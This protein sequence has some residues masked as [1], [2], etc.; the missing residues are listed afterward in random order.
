MT[1]DNFCFY[2][3]NR[4]IQTSQTGG[5][6]YS[7][8]FPGWRQSKYGTCIIQIFQ[9]ISNGAYTIGLYYK[10]VTIINDDS[11]VMLQTVAT[12]TSVLMPPAMAMAMA[13]KHL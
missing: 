7:L 4:L 13:N 8:V 1:A 11:R 2:L 6:W 12:L 10:H 3:Q 9:K 5:Q